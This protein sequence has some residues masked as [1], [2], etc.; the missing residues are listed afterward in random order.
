MPYFNNCKYCKH[1]GLTTVNKVA[2]RCQCIMCW[3]F[4]VPL[5]LPVS[6]VA[7]ATNVFYDTEHVCQKCHRHVA[8]VPAC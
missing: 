2:G 3:S 5:F 7:C 6:I 1:N 8:I 4:V